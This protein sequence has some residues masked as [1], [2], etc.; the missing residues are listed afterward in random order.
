MKRKFKAM[1]T[2]LLVLALGSNSLVVHNAKADTASDFINQLTPVVKEVAQ[3]YNLYPSLMMAQAALESGYGQSSL[4][5]KDYNYFGIKG[6]YDGQ[7]D[8]LKTAEYNSSGSIYY[9]TAAFKKYPNPQ[10]S[11]E[12]YAQLLRN[13]LVGSAN[14][15][16]GTW[17][18]NT[19]SVDDAATALVGKYATDPN[20]ANKLIKIINQYNLTSLDVGTTEKSNTVADGTTSGASSSATNSSDD[21]SV[22]IS[23]SN[24]G[25]GT[26]NNAATIS[27]KA[28]TS[29]ATV[30]YAS[31]DAD[32][33]VSLSSRFNQQSLYDQIP[34]DDQNVKTTGWPSNL[35]AGSAVY[36]DRVGTVKGSGSSQTWYRIRFTKDNNA[37]KYWVKSAALTFATAKY[38][39]LSPTIAANLIRKRV[40]YNHIYE[41]NPLASKLSDPS[42]AGQASLATNMISIVKNKNSSQLWVRYKTGA[43]KNAWIQLKRISGTQTFTVNTTKKLSAQYGKYTLYNNV[44]GTKNAQPQSWNSVSESQISSVKINSLAVNVAKKTIWAHIQIGSQWYWIDN[45]ALN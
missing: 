27:A 11:L 43:G 1:L 29:D 2:G 40:V 9:T 24:S 45:S 7:S 10:S 14:F 34:Q 4:S 35:S 37:Q 28:S 42:L 18:E 15:Y 13:G 25:V 19:K 36:V 21:N 41:T 17:K 5:T 30:N 31:V 39:K 38:Y 32:Q 12:D 3:K 44:P 22:K 33:R 20:Y 26:T 23:A 6:S 16:S 8:N